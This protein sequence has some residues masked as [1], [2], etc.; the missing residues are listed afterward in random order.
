MHPLPCCGFTFPSAQAKAEAGPPWSV[1]HVHARP[2]PHQKYRAPLQAKWRPLILERD[3]H[4]CRNCRAREELQVAHITDAVAFVRA[5][6]D[7]R[8]VTFSYRWD[9]LY[10]LCGR[11]H[12]A[13]HRF[14]LNE[15]DQERRWQVDELERGLRRLRGW[16]S[17]FAALPP[18]LLPPGVRPHRSYHDTLR[19]TPLVP[20][21]TYAR[22]AADGGH[23]HGEDELPPVQGT[24]GTGRPAPAP[25][26]GRTIRG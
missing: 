9:N 17:P 21:A 24:L 26:R 16:S 1:R 23:V 2:G 11:C 18:H 8:A 19:I 15:E 4:R 20:F 22:Y 3:R 7:H 25:L 12:R 10:T 13:S 5:A 6:G 14:R